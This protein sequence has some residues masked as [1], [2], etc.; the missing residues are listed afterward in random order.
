MGPLKRAA[1]YKATRAQ[2]PGD[3]KPFLSLVRQR[4]E[5][6]LTS[7]GDTRLISSWPAG[8]NSYGCT[9]F[10]RPE[11][12]DFASSTA[13]AI[14]EYA[15]ARANDA[16]NRL[17]SSIAVQTHTQAFEKA[18]ENSRGELR[19]LLALDDVEIVFSPS[20]TDAQLQALFLVKALLGAPLTTIIVGADQT[21]SGTTHTARGEHFSD[22]TA[23]GIAVGKGA[24]VVDLASNVRTVLV[25]FCDDRGRLRSRE[26]MDAEVL[27]TV[28]IAT[29][30]GEKILLQVM[31]ASKLGWRAPSSRCVSTI[32]QRWPDDVRVVVDA[33][34]MRLG[35][36]RL[37]EYLSCG[38][39]VMITGSKFFT[40]PAFSGALLVPPA[41]A[42]AAAAIHA[43]PAGLRDYSSW[44]DWPSHWI[45][46]RT[47]FTPVP[48][49]GQWL[50]WE[51]ALAEMNLY[52]EIP[53][54]Y[55]QRLFQLF[56]QSARRMIGESCR[57]ELLPEFDGDGEADG[58]FRHQTIF[59]FVPHR[60]GEALSTEQCGQ[61]YRAMGED[62]SRF[63]STTADD[64]DRIIA[65]RLCQIGQPV[66]LRHRSGAVL[67]LSAS[68]RLAARCWSRDAVNAK[69][70]LAPE[71]SDLAATI[72]KMNWLI[73]HPE[74]LENS[75]A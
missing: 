68:A 42:D 39:L 59:S 24:P 66:G 23:C 54:A 70:A 32:A 2:S 74:I 35:Q 51:A 56:A 47:A 71:R 3:E 31:D 14:S 61:L 17:W 10:P 46:L 49:Y 9:P 67:R 30:R 63:L 58:E 4:L 25:G 41:L 22:C 27:R 33:C 40:G 21:G 16:R 13:S 57:L 72:E 73:E 8:R 11:V 44:F 7:S 43:V 5:V 34:Q 1:A 69:D 64:K 18:V 26:E 62:V 53:L 6:L 19:R 36:D 37:R 65:S 55:R 45:G 60:D 75:S 38:Y 48:Q 50:R 12:I 20:G 29:G 52:F 15:Y 28:T